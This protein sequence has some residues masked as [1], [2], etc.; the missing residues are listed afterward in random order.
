MFR[1]MVSSRGWRDEKERY[2]TIA[3]EEFWDAFYRKEA[4]EMKQSKN[5]LAANRVIGVL[6]VVVAVVLVLVRL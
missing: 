3:E 1:L 6:T 4:Y 2:M 5:I